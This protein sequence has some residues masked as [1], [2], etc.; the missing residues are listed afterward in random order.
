MLFIYNAFHM[1]LFLGCFVYSLYSPVPRFFVPDI[2]LLTRADFCAWT[3]YDLQRQHA[4]EAEALRLRQ[5][6]ERVEKENER[7]RQLFEQE[8]A[9]RAA[10]LDR[11]RQLRAEEEKKNIVRHAQEQLAK[12]VGY[13]VPLF[14]YLAGVM[15]S[16]CSYVHMLLWSHFTAHTTK[17]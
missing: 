17:D 7:Q 11:E 4:E 8:R 12:C 3:C 5:E 6:R 2:R 16:S 10:E 9:K 1:P 14:A 15:R 13:C